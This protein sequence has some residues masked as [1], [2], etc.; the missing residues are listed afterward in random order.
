MK[1]ALHSLRWPLLAGLLVRIIA[2]TVG[3]GFH[4]RDDYFHVLLPAM[5]WL[6]EPSFDWDHAA[7]PGAGIR[8]HLV[9]RLIW[10][11][12]K[13]AQSLG[14][15]SPENILRFISVLVGLYSLSVIPAVYGTARR[16]C[17]K[18][19]AQVS[20]WAAALF[21][22]MPYSGT[23]LLIEAMSMPWVAMGVYFCARGIT[24]TSAANAVVSKELRQDGGYGPH[25]Y[26]LAGF[27]F[28]FACWLRY[29]TAVAAL[30]IFI[31]L[32]WQKRS[33][34]ALFYAAGGLVTVAFQGMFD[35][36][37]TGVFLGPVIRNINVNLHPPQG[38]SHSSPLTYLGMWLLLTAPPLTFAIGPA[39]WRAAKRLPLLTWPFVAFVAVHSL[40]AHKEERFML[41][42][43]P[44]FL[45]LLAAAWGEI[46]N[47]YWRAFAA[48]VYGAALIL[49]ITSQS[50]LHLHDVMTTLRED[51][52][53]TPIVFMGPEAQTFFLGST[54][55]PVY[56]KAKVDDIWLI[57]T[58]QD[59]QKKYHQLPNRFVTYAVDADKM[60]VILPLFG[61][62]CD[63]PE[64][65]SGW[66]LDKIIYRFNPKHN[67]RR[68]PI[69]LW[70]CEKKSMA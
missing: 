39:L 20:A 11:I 28:G 45:I 50:Q 21:F 69:L 16:L 48:V 36:A 40:I 53:P 43:M 59:A 19:T 10:C 55:P 15:S 3:I 2:A 54:Q 58:L 35:F 51:H 37:T 4:A 30:A 57:E 12:L 65:Y 68:S 60:M 29:Q 70:R 26:A 33:R 5:R 38:L 52:D 22:V 6:D 62:E 41:P 44:L 56:Q 9:P 34:D 61:L 18:K 1:Q 49:S 64:E 31:L 8:S 7:T 46:K 27:C 25:L 32:L 66:W 63:V 67:R 47:N 42:V 24:T 23:K 14:I 13:L 17:D